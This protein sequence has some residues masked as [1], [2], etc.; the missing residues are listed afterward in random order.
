MLEPG[1]AFERADRLLPQ[2][3]AEA[4]EAKKQAQCVI[5]PPL[6]SVYR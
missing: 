5:R 2:R 3:A 4:A 1:Q 6:S